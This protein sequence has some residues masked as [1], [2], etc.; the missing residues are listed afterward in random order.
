MNSATPPTE[1][2]SYLTLAGRAE[3]ELKIQRSRFLAL[4]CP[5]ADEKSARDVIAQMERQH[6][7]S[8]HVCYAW[9][10]GHGD[11]L[12]EIRSDCGEPSGS[13]GEPILNALRHVG[14]TNVVAVVARW[15]GGVKL[16]TGGLGR[17][18]RDTA[19]RALEQA[20]TRIVRLGKEGDV[21]FPYSLQ[22]TIS[23][24][25]AKYDGETLAEKYAEEVAWRV[26]LPRSAWPA[27]ADE[28]TEITAGRIRP[29][30]ED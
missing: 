11:D 2:E 17:A 9:R 7:D 23:R 25:I 30:A 19:A 28:V 16:G 27:F 12:C 18:Y 10:L 1:P 3:A 29:R 24:L 15:F 6:H 20:P 13:A 26:W 4:V 5:V 14:V 8:R 21:T 22:K